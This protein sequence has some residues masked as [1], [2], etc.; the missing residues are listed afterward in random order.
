MREKKIKYLIVGGY[1]SFLQFKDISVRIYFKITNDF[2]T[3]SEKKIK[4]SKINLLI[5]AQG[6][7]K[8][9][10]KYGLIYKN[11][12]LIYST[13]INEDVKDEKGNKRTVLSLTYFPYNS[14]MHSFNFF[15]SCINPAALCRSVLKRFTTASMSCTL[16]VEQSFKHLLI[17]TSQ[18]LV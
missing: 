15:G 3:F 4:R 6:A 10:N 16:Q 18:C 5:Q 8:I 1:L 17:K 11:R 13:E 2:S 7:S 9:G 14:L 12:L